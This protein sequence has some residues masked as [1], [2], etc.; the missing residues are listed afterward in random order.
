MTWPKYVVQRG[1]R[2]EPQQLLEMRGKDVLP[3]LQR[4]STA[5]LRP[6]QQTQAGVQGTVFTT[7]QGKMID[8]AHVWA[9]DGRVLI[10]PSPGR[11]A[12]LHPKVHKREYP[13]PGH[14]TSAAQPSPAQHNLC[15]IRLVRWAR[16]AA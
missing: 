13:K 9:C 6:L 5:D 14:R 3:L 15:K 12:E 1:Y 11:A 10:E 7:A 16:C 8:W 2:C 4:L